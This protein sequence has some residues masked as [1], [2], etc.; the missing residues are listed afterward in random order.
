MS[1]TYNYGYRV[2]Y[3]IIGGSVAGTSAVLHNGPAAF[4]ALFS[5]DGGSTYRPIF[6]FRHQSEQEVQQALTTIQNNE[7]RFIEQVAAADAAAQ[8][9]NTPGAPVPGTSF[10]TYPT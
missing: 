3:P 1:L 9:F 7:S 10:F 4:E 5:T 6:S 2:S 8:K